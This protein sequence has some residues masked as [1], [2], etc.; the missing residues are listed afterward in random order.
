MIFM[1][2]KPYNTHDMELFDPFHEFEDLERAM[3]GRRGTSKEGYIRTDIRE[4][5]GN[6]ILEAELPGFKKEDVNVELGGGCLTISASNNYE[7]EE[8]DEKGNFIMKERRCGSFTRTYDTEGIDV[9]HIK[10]AFENG[11]LTLTM[12]KLI[13]QKPETKLLEIE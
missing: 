4:K 3:F 12:P 11:V 5:D 6:Y 9:E 1:L 2:L 13:E 7:H 8:K 10:A